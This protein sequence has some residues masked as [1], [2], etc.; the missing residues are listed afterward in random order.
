MR[1]EHL[2]A[3]CGIVDRLELLRM[4][5]PHRALEAHPAELA[6][7]PRTVKNGAWKCPPAIACAP[8]P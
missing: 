5:E 7:R 4:R 1:L 8:S 3:R 2:L 6:R